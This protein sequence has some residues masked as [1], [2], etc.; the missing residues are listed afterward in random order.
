MFSFVF[1]FT[2]LKGNNAC[3]ENVAAE[4]RAAADPNI[5]SDERAR[6]AGEGDG[7]ERGLF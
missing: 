4:N 3:S 2:G 6:E 1:G 5:N 7:D